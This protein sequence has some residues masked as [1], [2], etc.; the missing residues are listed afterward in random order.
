MARTRSGFLSKTGLSPK[1]G[2]LFFAAGA[3]GVALAAAL[4]Y[5]A[6][7][8]ERANPPLG[9]FIDVDGVQLHYIERGE[10]QP[11]VLLHGQGLTAIDFETS[12]LLDLLSAKY[13]VIAFD[14]PGYGYSSRPRGKLWGPAAQA[15]LLRNALGR[16]GVERPTVVGHSWGTLVAIAMALEY[17]D[18]VRSLALLSGYYYPSL[19]FDV[20]LLSPPAIPVVGHIMRYTVSPLLGRLTWP[21]FVRRI[22]SPAAAAPRF[23]EFPVAMTLRPWQLRASAAEAA[24]LIPAAAALRRRYAQL[25]LPVIIVAGAADRYVSTRWHSGRLHRKLPGSALRL[26]P[27]VGHMVHYSAPSEVIDAIDW[28]AN[29]DRARLTTEESVS[30][31][32]AR[33]LGE[34][35]RPTGNYLT[36]H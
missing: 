26:V 25:T 2:V 35:S 7:R 27:G 8:T 4:H 30:V 23:A 9:K 28:A 19:R 17:P 20:G 33:T 29:A 1:G 36:G 16:L 5:G 11:V 24:L 3:A 10:G 15:K 6:R 13:R 18:Y 14:R 12:G 22:F 32:Q 21:L 34:Q 31:P